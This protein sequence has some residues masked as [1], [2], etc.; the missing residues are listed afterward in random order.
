MAGKV[1]R[2]WTDNWEG[3]YVNGRL[4]AEGHSL[5]AREALEAVGWAVESRE[6]DEEWITERGHLP[7]GIDRVRFAKED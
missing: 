3:L 5:D 6:L 1:T 4:V 7:D 2:V